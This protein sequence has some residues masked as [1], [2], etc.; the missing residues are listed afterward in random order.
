MFIFALRRL[1]ARVRFERGAGVATRAFHTFRG[2]TFARLH[3]ASFASYLHAFFPAA[4]TVLAGFAALSASPA[5]A[6]TVS[7][8]TTLPTVSVSA[9]SSADQ[10]AATRAVDPDLPATVETVDRKSVV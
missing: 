9:N 3:C 1:P 8:D 7:A 4:V 10:S 5:R 2:F 6:D